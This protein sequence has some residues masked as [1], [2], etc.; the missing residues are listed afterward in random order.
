MRRCPECG[1]PA[2]PRSCDDIFQQL[3]ALDHSRQPP[4]GPLHG[5]A[6]ACFFLQHSSRMPR[7][8]RPL[9][10]ALLHAYLRGGL[11]VAAAMTE[12]TRQ[13]NSQRGGGHAPQPG[14][15]PGAP[16]FPETEHPRSY[17]ITIADIALNGSFPA[18]GHQERVRSWAAYTISA[19][20]AAT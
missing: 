9:Y 11:G 12:R 10:W 3:L 16:P 20:Q 7:A 6:V 8:A 14:D 1:A 18:D 17:A 13:L 2:S 19:W 5:V 4:W 15:F